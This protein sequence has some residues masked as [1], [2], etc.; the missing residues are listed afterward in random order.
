MINI[1]INKKKFE[2][3]DFLIPKNELHPEFWIDNDLEKE[4]SLKLTEISTDILKQIKINFD[5]D[6][7][8]ITGS[9]A[10]FNWHKLSDIDLHIILDFKQIDDNFELVKRLL[11]EIRINWNKTHD[12]MIKGH[13]VELYF[14]HI[15]EEHESNGV[16]SVY[17]GEWRQIPKKTKS[18]FNL[19]TT[20]RKAEAIAKSIDHVEELFSR[21]EHEQAFRYAKKIRKKIST[22]RS[23]GLSDEGIYSPENLAFKML[24]N[25]NYL[26][27][28]SDLRVK[29]YDSFMSLNEM[30]LKD[31]FNEQVDDEHMIYGDGGGIDSLLDDS[32]P[33]PWEKDN[34][35]ELWICRFGANTY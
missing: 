1:S 14:Q 5:I 15:D 31:Y 2:N 23:S 13:E 16:W 8:V 6:D 18:D 10:G 9:I 17:K 26:Q 27:K 3:L 24:R 30:Y 25:S 7:V 35:N 29:S 22:M 33:A 11:D 20:E 19:R 32:V 12:I 4:I 28:L 34:K 21:G